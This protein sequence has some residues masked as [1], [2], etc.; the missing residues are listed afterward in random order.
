[1]SGRRAKKER[2]NVRKAYMS[3]IDEFIDFVKN[4]SLGERI[5]LAWRVINKFNGKC[6]GWGE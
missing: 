5:K 4:L 6:G 2:K 3:M 1:M